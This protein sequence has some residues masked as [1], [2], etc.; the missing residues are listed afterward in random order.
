MSLDMP[1]FA[2]PPRPD[3]ISATTRDLERARGK[4]S[5]SVNCIGNRHSI[6]DLGQSG[7]GRLLFPARI[8]TQ[9][10]EAVVVNTAGGL[11]GGDRFDIAVKVEEGAVA[12][13]TS[14]ACEK[15]YRATDQAAS[16]SARLTVAKGAT[17]HW[18]PQE[19]ILFDRSALDRSLVIDIDPSATL[20]AAEAVLLGRQAMGE[21]VETAR[22]RDRWRIRRG[23]RL[24]FAEETAVDGRRGDWTALRGSR[25]LLGDTAVAM[26]TIVHV[27]LDAG[28]RIDAVRAIMESTDIDGGASAFDGLLVMRMVAPS[29]LLLRKTLIR[30]LEHCGGR[31]LPRVWM[32]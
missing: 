22:L 21:S 18:L 4:V 26:A 20:L 10:L 27:A 14:Q 15:I 32:T 1:E 25:A 19:T 3:A 8:A 9:P 16:L 28:T 17:L 24:V 30:L 6:R 29:G 2:A 5:L 23:N 7:C 12:T 31:P 13:L 11:T